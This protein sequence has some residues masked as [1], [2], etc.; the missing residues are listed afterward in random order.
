MTDA[1]KAEGKGRF[2]VLASRNEQ[3]GCIVPFEHDYSRSYIKTLAITQP[4]AAKKPRKTNEEERAE[5][6]LQDASS[7]R[8]AGKAEDH[9]V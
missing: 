2:F 5:A 4:V 9:K 6:A 3:D 8:K 1:E 7:R